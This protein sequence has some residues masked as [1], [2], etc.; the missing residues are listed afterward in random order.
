LG[1]QIVEALVSQDLKGRFE[2]SPSPQ[3]T[4]AVIRFPSPS[5]AGVK[6]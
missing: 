4:R 3:G 1:L 6:P 2:L 5:I